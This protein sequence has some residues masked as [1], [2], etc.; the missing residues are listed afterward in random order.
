MR[1]MLVL[2]LLAA[3]A[4]AVD[5]KLGTASSPLEGLLVRDQVHLYLAGLEPG[6]RDSDERLELDVRHRSGRLFD[7][8]LAV[9]DHDR[10]V[11]RQTGTYSFEE[12]RA[13]FGRAL[14]TLLTSPP[15]VRVLSLDGFDAPAGEEAE[16]RRMFIEHLEATERIV[17]LESADFA[18]D[19]LGVRLRRGAGKGLVAELKLDGEALPPAVDEAGDLWR[20]ALEAASRALGVRLERVVLAPAEYTEASGVTR[21]LRRGPLDWRL[22]SETRIRQAAFDGDGYPVL[23][24]RGAR[25][26]IVRFGY[27]PRPIRLRDEPPGPKQ[28][29]LTPRLARVSLRVLA[30][31]GSRLGP[32]RLL[33]Y[34]GEELEVEEGVAVPLKRGAKWRYSMDVWRRGARRLLAGW[35]VLPEEGTGPPELYDEG[36]PDNL[37]LTMQEDRSQGAAAPQGQG[38]DGVSDD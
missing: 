31:P 13:G 25:I 16:L 5:L 28:V 2:C 8:T 10:P 3:P 17:V 22:G 9:F 21:M 7:Y 20:P 34:D 12:F 19:R 37:E 6:G 35:F 15:E 33:G 14:E 36:F 27:D 24:E 1:R 29:L 23:V 18:H 26:T 4:G 11:G 30:P 32:I 38:N